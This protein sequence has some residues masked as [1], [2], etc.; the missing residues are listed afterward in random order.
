MKNKKHTS[1]RNLN[2]YSNF[3]D[4]Q[5]KHNHLYGTSCCTECKYISGEIKRPEAP[6]ELL[7]ESEHQNSQALARKLNEVIVALNKS[8]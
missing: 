7:D 1:R 3:M 6:I 4:S 2:P 5:N 8:K